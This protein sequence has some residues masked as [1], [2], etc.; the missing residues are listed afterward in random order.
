MSSEWCV[1][2][3]E[4][5]CEVKNVLHIDIKEIRSAEVSVDLTDFGLDKLSNIL[6]FNLSNYRWPVNNDAIF[7]HRLTII[8]I[9]NYSAT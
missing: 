8:L 6:L 3:R 5:A 1:V 4:V 2:M 7:T 9:L